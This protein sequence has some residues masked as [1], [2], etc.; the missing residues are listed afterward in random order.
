MRDKEIWRSIKHDSAMWPAIKLSFDQMPSNLRQC[1]ALF[2]L[3]PCGYAFDSFDVTSLWGAFG[4][5]PSPN[6]NQILKHNICVNY[7]QDLFCRMLLTTALDFPLEYMSW[8][9]I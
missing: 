1:F 9:M 3:Y 8:C 6:R 7:V 4:L 2:N 5:L